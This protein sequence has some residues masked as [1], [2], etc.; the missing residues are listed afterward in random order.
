[1]PSAAKS[2]GGID[3]NFQPQFIQKSGT[4]VGFDH[5][6]IFAGPGLAGGFK[7]FDFHF[8]RFTSQLTVNGAFQL[9]LHP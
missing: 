4:G 1:M 8:V 6:D 9:M 3:L 5:A 2:P 7:G